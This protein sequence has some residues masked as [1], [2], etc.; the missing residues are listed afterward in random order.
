MMIEKD[1]ILVVDDDPESRDILK[2][3]LTLSDYE[4]E[5]VKGGEEAVELLKRA[6]FK[7]VLTDLVMPGMDGIKLLSHVKSHY[8]DISVIIVTGRA[9]NE[10]KKEALEIGVE[11]LLSKPFTR[12]QLLAIV[13]EALIKKK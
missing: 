8:P 7:L 12:D 5:S 4:V 2:R 6:E 13:S 1:R 3:L 9:S 11:G 10:S